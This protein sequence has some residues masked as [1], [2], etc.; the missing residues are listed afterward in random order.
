MT[1]MKEVIEKAMQLAKEESTK[2]GVP[3]WEYID[4]CNK[5]G[6]ELAVQLDADKDIVM[7]GTLL[8]DIKLG[9]CSKAGEIEKHIESG[10]VEA[11]KFLD[12]CSVSDDAKKKVINCIEAHHGT[13]PYIYKEAEICANADCYKFL[14]PKNILMYFSI[15]GKRF[16]DFQKVLNQVEYK[17]EEKWKTLSLDVCKKELELYYFEFK[18]FIDNS[19]L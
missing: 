8:M 10:V 9:E 4:F 13:I 18:K 5:K 11:T 17:M 7:L 6:Q 15:L 3:P 19:R 1:H 2:Y 14:Y 12:A 16:D